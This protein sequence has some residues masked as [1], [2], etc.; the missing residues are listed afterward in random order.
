MINIDAKCATCGHTYGGHKNIDNHCPNDKA[1]GFLET[2]FKE[3]PDPLNVKE[4]VNEHLK[5]NG[6]GGLYNWDGECGCEVGDLAPC[7]ELQQDCVPGY[8]VNCT[9]NCTHEDAGEKDAWHIQV[10]KP[11]LTPTPTDKG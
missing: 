8:K 7:G 3:I 1:P 2:A 10:E 9:K 4:I 11:N 5:A 6:Y